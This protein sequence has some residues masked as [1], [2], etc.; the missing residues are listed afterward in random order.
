MNPNIYYDS[1]IVMFFDG[2]HSAAEVWAGDEIRN[3]HIRS[4][5]IDLIVIWEYNIKHNF[6]EVKQMLLEK[7]K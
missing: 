2:P 5:G 7:L 6:D 3:D 1:D 4:F